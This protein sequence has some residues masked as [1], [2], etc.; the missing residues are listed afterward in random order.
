[1]LDNTIVIVTSDH[2]EQF[3]EHGRYDHGNSLYLPVLSV[4]LLI[5]CPGH[6]PQDT[7]VAQPVSMRDL[8]SVFTDLTGVAGGSPIPGTS[9]AR[10]WDRRR[11]TDTTSGSPIWSLVR[12]ALRPLGNYPT[13]KGAIHSLVRGDLHFIRNGDCSEALYDVVRDSARN[14]ELSGYPPQ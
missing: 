9:L 8:A 12:P 2:R 3:G 7:S 4:P 5:S 14:N 10:F 1:M 11:F 6:V 13:A